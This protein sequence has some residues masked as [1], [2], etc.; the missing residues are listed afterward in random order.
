LKLVFVHT[1]DFDS[2]VSKILTD[3]FKHPDGLPAKCLK[4]QIFDILISV[5]TAVKRK[6]EN[7][8]GQTRN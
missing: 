4:V 5:L 6:M 8:R 7:H 1:A 3:N 2:H